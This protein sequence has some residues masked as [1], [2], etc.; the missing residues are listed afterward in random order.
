MTRDEA[1]PDLSRIRTEIDGLDRQIVGLIAQ[2]QRLVESAGRLKAD[3]DAV[4]APD[5]VEAVVAK[6]RAIAVDA[7]A[8]PAVVEQTY[9]AMIGAFIALELEVHASETVVVHADRP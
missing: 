9:R 1:A 3:R 2:R 6:V 5:R 8:D 4:R 7:A